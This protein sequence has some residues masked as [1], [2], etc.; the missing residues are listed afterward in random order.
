MKVTREESFKPITITLET[1]VEADYFWYLLDVVTPFENYTRKDEAR[2]L[3]AS[4][5]ALFYE[6][7]KVHSLSEV[8]N[9]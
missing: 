5:G 1:K 7:D 8:E 2:M 3:S 4:G 9:E 6:Y